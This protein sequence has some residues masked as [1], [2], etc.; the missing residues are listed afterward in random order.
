[1]KMFRKIFYGLIVV[2]LTGIVVALIYLA[3]QKPHYN[4]TL[5][6]AGLH[7]Q[8]EV[9]YDYYGVPHIYAESE[10]DAYFA[11]GFV[12][13]QDRLFQMEMTRRVAS[14]TLSE[15]L[16]KDFVKVDAFFKTLGLEEHANDAASKFMSENTLPYQKAANAYLKGLNNFIK[17]GVTP[18]EFVMLGIDKKD[19]TI[20]DMYL[21]TE[22]M[23]FNFAMAFRTDPLMSYIHTKLGASYFKD[24]ITAHLDSVLTIPNYIP[25]ADSEDSSASSAAMP[26]VNKLSAFNTSNTVLDLIPI[27]PF[28]GSNGWVVAPKKSQSG[29]VLLGNDT[30]IGFGQPAVWYEAHLEYPGYSFYGNHLAGFPFAA[31]GH[32]RERAWGLTMFENDDLD[33]YAERIKP[34]DTS[35]YW[36]DGRWNSL[37]SEKKIIKVKGEEDVIITVVNSRHGPLVQNVMPEWKQVTNNP[38][39]MWWTHLKF[40]NN[41]MQVT[42]QMNHAQ[43]FEEFKNGVSK[44]ISPGLNVMYGDKEGNIAWWAAGRLMSRAK[45]VNPVLLID[46]SKY[47][48]DPTGYLDFSNNPHSE[49]PESGIVYSANNQPD[50]M[51]GQ[52]FYPG[53]Y[54]PSDRAERIVDLFAE[55]NIFSL[56][57]L[58]RISLDVRSHVTTKIATIILNSVRQEVKQKSAAHINASK[59]L[60]MWDGEHHLRSQAPTVYYKLLYYVLQMAMEDEL[61]QENFKLLLSTHALKNSVLPFVLNDSSV[62]WNDV[63]SRDVKESRNVIFERAF[64]MTVTDLVKQLGKNTDT[65]EWGRVHILE[66]K[67]PIGMKKPFNVMFNIGPFPVAGGQEV[68]NQMG[69][70]L[71][72]GGVYRVKYGPAMRIV[73][74]LAD[75]ENSKSVLPTGQSGN[76]MSRYYSDQSNMY[77]SGKMRKQKMNRAEI[78]SNR[79]GRLVLEP[80]N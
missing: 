67:H 36:T 58:H 2:L 76:V 55:K 42:Y 43:S 14:G 37:K 13:A 27:S 61:G 5:K 71:N 47:N 20:K 28:T 33:F 54:T 62:W 22:F 69:F 16:G 18:V 11:L 52:G 78:E 38:V 66:H 30:H 23:A 9:I 63:N 26:Q 45:S 79:S 50:S 35:K 41:L 15:I 24:I 75:I 64:D 7:S 34:G 72:G 56:E 10:E 29:R 12:H 32:T 53:Y 59:I 70:D 31:I 25:S 40:S 74:D 80:A 21:S 60:L 65:W 49:N 51:P 68:I 44:L 46:G 6:M 39:A 73:L 17:E 3:S 48:N 4:G 8:V 57:D 1:M 77:N 19:F